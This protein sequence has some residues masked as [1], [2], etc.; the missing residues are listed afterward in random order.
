MKGVMYVTNQSAGPTLVSIS[1]NVLQTRTKLSVYMYLH[2]LWG[3]LYATVL[4]IDDGII[5]C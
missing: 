5:T 2:W 4:Y 3:T 1:L